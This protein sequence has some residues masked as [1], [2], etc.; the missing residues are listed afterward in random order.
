MIKFHLVE[1]GIPTSGDQ[2]M[3]DPR[4]YIR[5]KLR[6]AKDTLEDEGSGRTLQ[7]RLRD[8]WNYNLVDLHAM[9]FPD[10]DAQDNITAIRAAFTRDGEMIEER[11][12]VPTTTF[13]MDETSAT[14]LA[15]EILKLADRYRA[16]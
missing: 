5:S 16:S 7:E 14:E 6:G 8:A 1:H 10:A 13:T 2:V 12:N 15:E 3:A 9:W 4:S 11:G